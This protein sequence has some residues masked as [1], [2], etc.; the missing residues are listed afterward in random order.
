MNNKFTKSAV[1]GLVIVLVLS[2]GVVAAFAQDDTPPDTDTE[3]FPAPAMPFGRGDF[4]GRGGHHSGADD[5]AL[6]A[7]LGITQEELQAARQ[8]VMAERLAQA[9]EDGFLTQDQANTM[10]A[11]EALKSYIDRDAILAAALGMTVEEVEA[12]REDDTL[13]D[14]MAGIDQTELQE[15]TQA[16]MEAAVQ[17]A[18]SDNVITQD[19][20][21]LVLEQMA[22]GASLLGRSGGHHHPGN[23]GGG[24]GGFRTAPDQTE[25][26]ESGEAAAPFAF[27]A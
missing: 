4:G 12:A 2:L 27:G 10:L 9:V 3:T 14:L 15:K 11:M 13:Y 17:Q 19:Q 25:D 8:E 23:F 16:A 21:D 20:A 1:I 24:R 5:E 26:T 22:N 7:A 18:V 6:A